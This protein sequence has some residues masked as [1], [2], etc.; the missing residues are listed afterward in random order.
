M[1]Y[2]QVFVVIFNSQ[3]VNFILVSENEYFFNEH[4]ECTLYI[5]MCIYFYVLSY[6]E[7]HVNNEDED[8]I[9]ECEQSIG[10]NE[11]TSNVWEESK[12][13]LADPAEHDQ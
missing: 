7:T 11:F 13:L 9:Q 12:Q 2:S 6:L 5:Y 4:I 8:R 3:V 1:S 10:N